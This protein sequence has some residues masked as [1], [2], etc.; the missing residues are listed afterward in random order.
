MGKHVDDP[1]DRYVIPPQD[2]PNTYEGSDVSEGV[3]VTIVIIAGLIVIAG[4][5][6]LTAMAV[7]LI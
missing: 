2:M 5:S 7:G 1:R 3:L 6:V 4:L